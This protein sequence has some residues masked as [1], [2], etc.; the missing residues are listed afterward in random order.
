M[1]ERVTECGEQLALCLEQQVQL[2]N[3]ASETAQEVSG[4]WI[5]SLA[6]SSLPH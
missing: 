3:R 5:G 2:R 4:E 6:T 1:C